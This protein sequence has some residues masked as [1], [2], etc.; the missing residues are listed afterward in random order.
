MSEQR[1]IDTATRQTVSVAEAAALLDCSVRQL[2]KLAAEGRPITREGKA[3]V[4]PIQIGSKRTYSVA[5]IEALL[6]P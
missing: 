4:Y 2:H 6:A 5:A 1:V 3:P